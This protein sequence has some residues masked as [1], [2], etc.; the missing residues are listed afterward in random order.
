MGNDNEEDEEEEEEEKEE[1]LDSELSISPLDNDME[2]VQQ[3]DTSDS[4]ET[5]TSDNNESLEPLMGTI[6]TCIL[7]TFMHVVY[8]NK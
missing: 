5:K 6:D 3:E 8:Y 2:E 1:F 7:F 4:N